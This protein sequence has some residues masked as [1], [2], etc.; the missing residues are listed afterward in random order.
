MMSFVRPA[1]CMCLC[2]KNGN[3]LRTPPSQ[4][5][6]TDRAPC[7]PNSYACPGAAFLVACGARRCAYR[8]VAAAAGAGM[9][10]AIGDTHSARSILRA[11]MPPT[12]K[13]PPPKQS[14]TFSQPAD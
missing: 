11:G 5:H 13:K 1:R 7:K 6:R 12:K 10:E 14:Q 3:H 4:R 9:R 2:A 8:N